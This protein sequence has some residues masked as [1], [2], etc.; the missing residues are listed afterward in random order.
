MYITSHDPKTHEPNIFRKN[1]MR[2]LPK[3]IIGE[4][5]LERPILCSHLQLSFFYR[6]KIGFREGSL[7][8]LFLKV[9]EGNANL[10]AKVRGVY[11]GK[12]SPKP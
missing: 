12:R 4:V 2:I 1:K 8:D 3:G 11:L 6:R 5:V 9:A 10:F 7:N